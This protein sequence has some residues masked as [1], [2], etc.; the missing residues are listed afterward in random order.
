VEDLINKI[1][2]AKLFQTLRNKCPMGVTF[3][4][5]NINYCMS[6]LIKQNMEEHENTRA[7]LNATTELLFLIDFEGMI[8][9]YNSAF[10]ERFS[11]FG[12]NL[13]GKKM[14]DLL[15]KEV[16]EKRMKSFQR[17][18]KERNVIRFTDKNGNFTFDN[19][20][21]PIFNENHELQRIAV[22][23]KNITKEQEEKVKNEILS[24]QLAESERMASIGLIS[25]TIAHEINNSLSQLFNKLYFFQQGLSND[26]KN[27]LIWEETVQMKQILLNLSNLSQN[28]LNYSQP[29]CNLSE[30]VNLCFIIVYVVSFFKNLQTQNIDYD[31]QL[32]DNV[33]MIEGD[34]MGLEIVLKNLISNAVKSIQDSGKIVITLQEYPED[35]VLI[36]IED[37]GS[38]IPKEIIEKIYDPF[39]TTKREKGGTGLGLLL[40]KKIVN[41]H[42]GSITINSQVNQGTEVQIILPIYSSAE[43]K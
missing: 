16:A 18:I 36:K 26:K 6:K 35:K 22:Y 33:P 10:A 30:K 23:A 31:L 32:S 9:E 29:K 28:I 7:I 20:A 4:N 1:K 14:Q 17:C 12:K 2:E 11:K 19:Q 43:K 25:S 15:P 3:N 42:G 38:G 41:D 21:Y 13:K 8:I 5:N 39:Y 34:S 27:Y 24:N 40:C 37:N